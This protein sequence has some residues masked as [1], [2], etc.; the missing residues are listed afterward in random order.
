MKTKIPKTQAIIE[1]GLKS[2]SENERKLAAMANMSC[3]ILLY[4]LESMTGL[5]GD[6][7]VEK[8]LLA[9]GYEV[10]DKDISE[11]YENQK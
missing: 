4:A 2:E 5:I 10:H 7:A 1:Q 9:K 3:T 6:E 8:V 11:A